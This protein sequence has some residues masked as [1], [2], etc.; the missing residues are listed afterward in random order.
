MVGD[1]LV[2]EMPYA[3]Q[4]ANGRSSW[5]NRSRGTKRSK[6]SGRFMD[7]KKRAS[8]KPFKGVRKERPVEL[9]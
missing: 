6:S 8:R 4:G 9:Q 5:P 1:F 7:Q 3:R 2:V